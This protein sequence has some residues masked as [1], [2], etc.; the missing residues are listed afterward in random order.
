[1]IWDVKS[2]SH[3]I[4]TQILL[5][6]LHTFC[7]VLGAGTCLKIKTIYLWW[8]FPYFLWPVCV[9]LGW[10]YKEKFD[11]DHHWALRV[12]QPRQQLKDC[13]LVTATGISTTCAEVIIRVKWIVCCHLIAQLNVNGRF[14]G[15]PWCYWLGCVLIRCV[16]LFR[17]VGL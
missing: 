12:K 17:S 4:I 5:T 6:G 2:V 13:K 14:S 15:G 16:G 3:S 9:T 8:S 11:A 10:F 1:M 7:C